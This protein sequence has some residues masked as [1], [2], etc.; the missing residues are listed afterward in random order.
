MHRTI[1]KVPHSQTITKH[2]HLQSAK[3]HKVQSITHQKTIN[4][5]KGVQK[6]Y[7]VII[8]TVWIVP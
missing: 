3:Y 2:E 8:F 5:F 4:T 1:F 7:I 6:Q